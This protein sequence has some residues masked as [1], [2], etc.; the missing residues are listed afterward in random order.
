VDTGTAI[1]NPLVGHS[2]WVTSV[3]FSP[4]SRRIISGSYDKTVRVWDADTG[5][6]IGNPLVG[7]SSAVTS[8]A[9]SP[10][11]HRIISGSDD[12]TVRVWNTDVCLSQWPLNVSRLTKYYTS[13]GWVSLDQDKLLFWLP[14]EYRRTQPDDSLF[15]ITSQLGKQPVWLDYSRFAHGSNWANIFKCMN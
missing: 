4:D 13:D 9:F 1:G 15:V 6:A 10:D 14:A 7:H 2:N 12:N 3:A 11:S 5:I 8:V